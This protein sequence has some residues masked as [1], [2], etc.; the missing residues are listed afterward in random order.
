MNSI[1]QQK[2]IDTH[3][4]LWDLEKYSYD[5]IANASNKDLKKNYLL[6]NFIQDSI[7][8]NIKKLS[9]YKQKLIQI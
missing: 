6:E 5:W 9:M 4:H 2:I 7:F 3:I 1:Y 8:L